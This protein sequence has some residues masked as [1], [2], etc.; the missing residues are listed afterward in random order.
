MARW[1]ALL[2]LFL[3]LAFP[4]AVPSVTLSTE[5]ANVQFTYQFGGDFSVQ[6][7][8]S[9]DAQLSQAN[10]LIQSGNNA[11]QSFP[12]S[13]SQQT[14]L[15]GSFP[16]SQ[17]KAQ[18]FSRLYYWFELTSVDG[19]TLTTPA[20]WVDY[21][22]NRYSWQDSESKWFVIHWVNGQAPSGDELQQLALNGLK[23]ATQWVPVSP[24]LPINIYVYP[25]QTAL[26]AVLDAADPSGI[27]GEAFPLN[28]LILVSA[29]AD[30]NS[31]QD[32]ERQIPHELTHLLEYKVTQQNYSAAPAWLMEGLAVNAET[33]PNADYARVLEKAASA[34]D[35]IPLEK[36][37]SPFAA[38]SATSTQSYAESGA[39]VKYLATTYG[40]E[41]ILSLLQAS[42]SGLDCSHQVEN[43]YGQSLNA[44]EQSWHNTL[45]SQSHSGTNYWRYWPIYIAILVLLSILFVVRRIFEKKREENGRRSE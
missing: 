12:L 36:L 39:F 13:L 27:A 14:L 5:L 16:T 30:L 35:W 24:N 21:I 37:C 43:T 11:V 2:P 19:T 9:P 8:I 7:E 38:D 34:S 4:S 18:P 6:A 45:Q 41:R 42:A 40:T 10:L 44:L 26:Q 22:D 1:L 20:Y 29:S 17:L 25:D 3:H 33:Y 23:Q 32:L 31:T 15:S 28:N